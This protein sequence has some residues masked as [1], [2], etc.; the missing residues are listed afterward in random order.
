MVARRFLLILAIGLVLI[1]FTWFVFMMKTNSFDRESPNITN[2][3]IQKM[4]TAQTL[5]LSSPA[6]ENG[7]HIPQT[8]ACDGRNINPELIID[9]APEGTQSFALIVEDSDAPRGTFIHWIMWNIPSETVR[10]P[11]AMSP[12]G[13]SGLNS[14]D[15]AGYA[16]PCPPNGTHHYIFRVFALDKELALDAESHADDLIRAMSG[17]VLEE[18]RLVGL[19]ERIK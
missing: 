2:T 13:I 19:Y 10:I 14:V 9:G 5:R 4:K 3:S 11:E 15:E 16:G 7:G 18:V 8:Y 6:F 1:M 12:F 17:H